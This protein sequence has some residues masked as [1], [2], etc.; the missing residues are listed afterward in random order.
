MTEAILQKLEPEIQMLAQNLKYFFEQEDNNGLRAMFYRG[1]EAFFPTADSITAVVRPEQTQ[2]TDSR[3]TVDVRVELTYQ[4][5]NN[6][7]QQNTT[8]YTWRLEYLNDDWMLTRVTPQ[9]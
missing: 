6:Q 3:A 8:R 1:W 2:V 7:S 9:Q 4:D 5:E